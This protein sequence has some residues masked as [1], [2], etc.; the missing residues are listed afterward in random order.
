MTAE[1]DGGRRPSDRWVAGGVV[2]AVVVLAL[3]GL[4][5]VLSRSIDGFLLADGTGYLANARWLVGE[6]GSTWQGPAAFYHA[7]WSLVMAPVYLFTRSPDA[8]HTAVLVVNAV[9]ASLAFVAYAA[10]AEIVFGLRR[11]LALLAG[12][13]AAT[14]PAVLLQASFEWSESLF[15]LLFPLFVLAAA[16]LVRTGSP[17]AGVALG[18]AAAALNATHPK[19]LGAVVAVGIGLAALGATERLPRRAAAAGLVALALA[20]VATRAL[21]GALQDALY[22]E[23]AAAIEG[24]VLA[25][26]SDPVE[27]WGAFRAFWGQVWYAT[28]A[29]L[30]LAPLGALTLARH[31]DRR[32]AGLVLGTCLVMLAASCLQMSDGTRVDHMVYGRYNEGFLPV[33]LVAGVAGVVAHRH[34]LH[35]LAARAALLAAATGFVAVALRGGSAFTGDVMPL[36][37]TG[38]LVYRTDVGAI[39]VRTVTVLAIA[40]LVVVAALTRWRLAAGGALLVAFFVGS[41]LSVEA[42]TIRPWADYWASVT[43]IPAIVDRLDADG[44]IAYDLGA[45]HVDAADLYQLELTHRGGLLFFDSRHGHRP[46]T[47][48]AIA[49]PHWEQ[50]GARLVYAEAGIFRQ[51]LWVMP[52]ALQDDL[53]ARGLLVPEQYSAPLPPAARRAALEVRDHGG[54]LVVR[55]RNEGAT[56]LPV[57]PVPGVVDGTVRLGVRLYAGDDEVGSITRELPRVLLPGDEVTVRVPVRDLGISVPVRAVVSLRQESVAWWDESAVTLDLDLGKP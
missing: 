3:V 24:G 20:F 19:G 36:N 8:V 25:R 4:H 5:L 1:V 29:T 18:L 12:L 45:Y 48:L 31:R 16:W 26:L 14:Y 53:A 46:A 10:V 55:V 50:P 47:D 32:L 49:S 30:G 40:A 43:E 13:V 7:G 38:V 23:S 42:R 34:R 39:D 9:L 56:W 11:W 33:L 28:V 17:A 27:V 21:H 41:S 54:D 35:H 44:P 37:V 15:H 22:D 57:G 51:A 52:G 6:A 2:G